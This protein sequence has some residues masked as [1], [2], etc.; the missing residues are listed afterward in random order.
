[1][2][3]TCILVHFEGVKSQFEVSDLLNEQ[4]DAIKSSF[5]GKNVPENLPNGFGKSLIC[6]CLPIVADIK[7][8]KPCGSSVIFDISPLR[9][10]FGI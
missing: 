10:P 2:E 3:I 5:Q 8:N 4:R 7:N 6:Q 1:M 9:S